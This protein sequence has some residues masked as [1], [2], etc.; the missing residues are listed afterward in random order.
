MAATPAHRPLRFAAVGPDHGHIFDP[1]KGLKSCGAQFI[2]YY[3]SLCTGMPVQLPLGAGHP[4]Y[5]S[6]LPAGAES[7]HG[8]RP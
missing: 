6:W 4:L 8:V 1:I 2:G 3:H 7:R 5:A